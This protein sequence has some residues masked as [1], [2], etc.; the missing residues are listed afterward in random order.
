MVQNMEKNRRRFIIHE[1]MKPGFITEENQEIVLIESEESGKSELKVRLALSDN[2]CISNVDKKNTELQFFQNDQGKSMNKRV[3]HIIF[4]HQWDDIWKLYLIE[5]KSSVGTKK[6]HEIKGK[7]RVSYLLSHAVAG[8]LELKISETRMYTTFERVRFLPSETIPTARRVK[9]GVQLVR[10]E[11]E[12]SG[13]AACRLRLKKEYR[14]GRKRPDSARDG[15]DWIVKRCC[16]LFWE[17]RILCRS[18][19][20]FLSC[21]QMPCLCEDL[22]S[23]E[24]V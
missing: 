2:L 5:M 16:Q 23:A 6:W 4:E 21:G 22:A 14:S 18:C 3:D 1:L 19:F 15:M 9:P 12:W 11:E 10:M 17:C 20:I 7:F 24:P 13:Q 8:M